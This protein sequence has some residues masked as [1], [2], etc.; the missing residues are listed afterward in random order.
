[1][2]ER[3][4]TKMYYMCIYTYMYELYHTHKWIMSR[5]WMTHVTNMNE[6]CHNVIESCQTYE[7][8]MLHVLMRH[9]THVTSHTYEWVVSPVW[10][11][12]VKKSVSHDS[13]ILVTWSYMCLCK[14]WLIYSMNKTWHENQVITHSFLW[15]DFI[16][17]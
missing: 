1:M 12:H 3:L 8:V 16:L 4:L 2:R 17:T 5:T 15:H 14:S 10:V 13:F 9:V 6:A 7:W 11:V